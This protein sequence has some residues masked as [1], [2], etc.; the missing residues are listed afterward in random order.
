[1]GRRGFGVPVD[2]AGEH[3]DPTRLCADIHCQH[4]EKHLITHALDRI[5]EKG[6]SQALRKGLATFISPFYRREKVFVIAHD[7]A[8][9]LPEPAASNGYEYRSLAPE[10]VDLL[11]DLVEPRRVKR[12]RKRLS[13]GQ[14]CDA[15]FSEGKIVGFCWSSTEPVIDDLLSF[16]IPVG[17][18][19]VYFYDSFTKK[20]ERCKGLF[21]TLLIKGFHRSKQRGKKRAIAIHSEDDLI[22]VYPRYRRKGIPVRMT[23]VVKFVRVLFWSNVKWFDYDSE[24]SLPDC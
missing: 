23:K 8:G 19:E 5:R 14:R 17:P 20:S 7:L 10:E 11:T 22:R 9:T 1:M 18:G 21:F 24:A 16:E 4:R 15:A 2:R 6:I 3:L 13:E 12:Y